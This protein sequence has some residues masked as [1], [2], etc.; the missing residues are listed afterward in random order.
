MAGTPPAITY[1]GTDRLTT[2]PAATTVCGLSPLVFFPG[3]GSELYRGLGSV[4][5]GGLLVSAFFT[6][7]LV[8]T[9][10]SLVMDT[11]GWVSRTLRRQ[12]LPAPAPAIA[13][14]IPRPAT[15]PPGQP[16][17]EPSLR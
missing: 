13:D 8:P 5:L 11:A 15:R 7:V 9:V 17:D 16:A 3:A 4:V 14:T 12:P 10:F 1:A 6:V 2:A